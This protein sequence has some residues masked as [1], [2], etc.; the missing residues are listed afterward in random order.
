MRRRPG[1]RRVY[2]KRKSIGTAFKRA[3]LQRHITKTF[4]LNGEYG[5]QFFYNT[6]YANTTFSLGQL[7]ANEI[8]AIQELYDYYRI[9]AIKLE[10]Y[11]MWNSASAVNG[12][13]ELG[14]ARLTHVV[15][16]NNGFPP[17]TEQD[18]LQNRNCKSP[19]F[20]RVIKKY[21]KAMPQEILNAGN[22][23]SGTMPDRQRNLW[24]QTAEPNVPHHGIHFIASTL[25]GVAGETS[26]RVLAT[27]Y[28]T[29]KGQ[30]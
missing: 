24:I 15:D 10:F 11:P 26:F 7:P 22:P 29:F 28:M 14:L 13:P 23:A 16:T 30:R 9:D 20:T 27:Y 8:V 6:M 21:F 18:I 17:A 1:K 3:N 5:Q 4:Q 2:R 12:Q 25:S 19:L